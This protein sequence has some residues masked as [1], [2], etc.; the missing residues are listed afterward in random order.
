MAD[1]MVGGSQTAELATTHKASSREGRAARV[2]LGER[3]VTVAVVGWDGEP[4]SVMEGGPGKGHRHIKK[5]RNERRTPSAWCTCIV[6]NLAI[7]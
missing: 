6:H 5:G 1:V 7:C 4:L 3:L 2:G